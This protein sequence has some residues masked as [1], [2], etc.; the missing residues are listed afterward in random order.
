MEHG[1]SVW[2]MSS[3]KTGLPFQMFCRWRKFSVGKTQKSRVPFTIKPDF[4]TMFVNG[5]QPWLCGGQRLKL[6]R[7]RMVVHFILGLRNDTTVNSFHATCTRCK[8]QQQTSKPT[9]DTFRRPQ[10]ID[11]FLFSVRSKQTNT[12]CR[13]GYRL[14]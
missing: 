4:Q 9:L 5:E 12:G 7:D 13:C 3:G 10:M 8:Q 6:C 2:N 1:I 14:N 11:L